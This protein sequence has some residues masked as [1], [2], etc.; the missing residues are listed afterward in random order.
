MISQWKRAL[1]TEF[2]GGRMHVNRQAMR[3]HSPLVYE[4]ELAVNG[5]ARDKLGGLDVD[6][7]GGLV[8]VQREEAAHHHQAGETGRFFVRGVG[9]RV[10]LAA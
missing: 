2:T 9:L 3:V 4:R 5:A 1:A 7:F 10:Q 8:G 6:V